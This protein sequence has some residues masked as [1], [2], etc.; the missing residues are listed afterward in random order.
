MTRNDH[1]G[2]VKVYRYVYIVEREISKAALAGDVRG[3]GDTV[4]KITDKI[5]IG[6]K[7]FDEK[8]V[9]DDD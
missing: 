4:K 9:S 5:K 2:V 6:K 3:P 7:R 8:S 1:G